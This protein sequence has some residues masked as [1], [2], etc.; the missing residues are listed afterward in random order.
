MVK[1]T[2][3]YDVLGIKPNATDNEIKKGYKKMALQW[4][5]DKNQKQKE[6]AEKKFKEVAE[7]Y[8]VLS[9]KEK[10]KK[11]DQY[12]NTPF[13]EQ[14]FDDIFQNQFFNQRT[15]RR[16]FTRTYT[17]TTINPE[18]MFTKFF[19]NSFFENEFQEKEVQKVEIEVPIKELYNGTHKKFIIK[20][21]RFINSNQTK[22]VEKM[23]EFDIKPGYKD[24]T[25]IAFP[26]YGEQEHP[27]KKPKDLQFI[28]KTLNNEKF[29]RL[30]G[31]NLEYTCFISLKQSLCGGTIFIEHLNGKKIKLPLKGITTPETIRILQNEGFPNSKNP[32][33][34]GELYIKFKIEFPDF[35]KNEVKKELEKLL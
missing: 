8:A 28:I 9:D 33:N 34:K 21:K 20:S 6:F 11:Y 10:R 26:E 19:G 29:K 7:A 35:I 3:Y 16:N 17:N 18:E 25:K 12:G 30:E 4:H 22:E 1:D 31:D 32:N 27:T 15:D 24:G 2:K 14:N 13:Q 23:V 5:P